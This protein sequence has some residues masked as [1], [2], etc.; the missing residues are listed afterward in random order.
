MRVYL[1]IVLRIRC[2]R[3]INNN[4][5]YF[6]L[7]VFYKLL[8][9]E[10]NKKSLLPVVTSHILKHQESRIFTKNAESATTDVTNW[11]VGVKRNKQ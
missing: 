4:F 6:A 2:V 10:K 1:K 5:S 3:K 9:L 11:F 8:L 7:F